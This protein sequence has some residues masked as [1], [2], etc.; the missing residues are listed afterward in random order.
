M[1]PVTIAQ[2]RAT[3]TAPVPGPHNPRQVIVDVSAV[4]SYR[5]SGCVRSRDRVRG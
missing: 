4:A 2:L 3:S 5:P 1:T